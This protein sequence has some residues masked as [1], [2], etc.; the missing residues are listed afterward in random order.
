QRHDL[1]IDDRVGHLKG[2]GGDD[3][4]RAQIAESL[5][6]ALEQA[7]AEIVVLVENRDLGV[8]PVAADVATVD[9]A[10]QLEARVE[11]HGESEVRGVG[12]AVGAAGDQELRYLPVVEVFLDRSVG[13]RAERAEDEGDAVLLN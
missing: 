6:Q 7:L 1:R 11:A 3:E 8:G 4:F 2:G 10:L 9:A 13:R 5:L 12:K